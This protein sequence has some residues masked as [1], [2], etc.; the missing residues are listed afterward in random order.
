MGKHFNN[1]AVSA[2]IATLLLI[3]IAV[4]AAIIVYVFSIGLLGGL[5]TSG[6][7]QVKQQVI[8]EAYNWGT[9]TSLSITLRNVGPAQVTFADWFI[10]GASVTAPS[11]T[12]SSTNPAY[13]LQVGSS[14]VATFG[15]L[16]AGAYSAGVSYVVKVVSID[17]AVFSY[18][19]IAGSNS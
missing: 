3:A 10:N 5:Q 13:T 12:C 15:T 8:M 4:A 14:C 11:G 18:S 19:A 9:L 17:G 1:R 7:Q 6:G 16:T 2:V